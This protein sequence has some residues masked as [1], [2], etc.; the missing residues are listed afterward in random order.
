[1]PEPKSTLTVET[2]LGPETTWVPASGG[3]ALPDH[4]EIVVSDERY[5]PCRLGV[6]VEGGNPQCDWIRVERGERA[7]SVTSGALRKIPVAR[8]LRESV[9]L[10]A[11]RLV[12]RDDG[13][14]VGEPIA[15]VRVS[16]LRLGRQFRRPR[17]G[18]PLSEDDLRKVAEVYRD[19][20]AAGDP[21]PTATVARIL[22]VSRSTAG[23]WVGRARG[24]G[25][26]GP[27]RRRRAG[28]YPREET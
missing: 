27:A 28:E 24:D 2:P 11:I 13:T 26:L 6:R 10:A 17:R 3:L 18:F 16:P 22:H 23:R 7:A 20:L 5:P 14:V 25:Y 12:T 15:G 8:F 21:S 19:A 1:M 9:S 4:Y